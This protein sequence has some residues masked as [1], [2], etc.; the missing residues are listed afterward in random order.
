[1]SNNN[2][3]NNSNNKNSSKNSNKNNNNSTSPRAMKNINNYNNERRRRHTFPVRRQLSYD[4]T[5]YNREMFY[6]A[7]DP[8]TAEDEEVEVPVSTCAPVSSVPIIEYD[9]YY[10]FGEHYTYTGLSSPNL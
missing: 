1:M 8:E 3:H 4:R 6:K 7:Y 5:L 2:D 9:K 10:D